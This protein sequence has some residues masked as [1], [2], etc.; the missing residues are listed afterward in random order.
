LLLLLLPPGTRS[1]ERDPPS[2]DLS[3][4]IAA[5]KSGIKACNFGIQQ[6]QARN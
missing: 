1:I 4:A 5:I 3:A 2:W 6:K